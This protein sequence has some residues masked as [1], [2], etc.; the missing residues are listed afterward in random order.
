MRRVFVLLLLLTSLASCGASSDAPDVDPVPHGVAFRVEQTRQDLRTR[1][2]GLQVVNRGS[3][4]ITVSRV[5][6]RSGRFDGTADYRGPATVEPGAE[7][8]L[9]MRMPEARCGNGIDMTATIVYSVRGRTATS[10]VRPA[11]HYGSVARFMRRDCAEAALGEV[12]IDPT[13]EVEGTGTASRLLVGVTFTPRPSAGSVHVGPVEG[14]TLLKPTASG[15]VDHELAGR[16]GPY[17]AVLEIV[18]N[19]CDVHVVAEDRTGAA[20]PVH[21]SSKE[22]GDVIVYLRLDEAQRAQVFEFV[23]AHCGFARS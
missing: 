14:T 15:N 12:A 23:A 20:M 11:D 18:P 10:V 1:N 19:R 17:R 16:D 8:N 7:V 2:I 22:S 9:I 4:A 5:E 3:R 6:L 13:F 21:V